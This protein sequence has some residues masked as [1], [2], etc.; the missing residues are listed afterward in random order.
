MKR[1]TV[2]SLWIFVAFLNCAYAGPFGVEM[3]M[4]IKEIDQNAISKNPGLYEVKPPK[5]HHAFERYFVKVGEKTGLCMIRAAGQQFTTSVYGN[6]IRDRLTRLK[7]VSKESGM[8][9]ESGQL[10]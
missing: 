9:T 10:R 7:E 5:N 1:L 4:S 6:E 3:G 2:L 8:K